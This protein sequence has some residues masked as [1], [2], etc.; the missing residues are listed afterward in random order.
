MIN[1]DYSAISSLY[2]LY[3]SGQTGSLFGGSSA[4]GKL[5]VASQDAAS[6]I[7]SILNSS[8]L[9]SIVGGYPSSS[10]G[11]IFDI[12]TQDDGSNPLFY[13]QG[14]KSGAK[15]LKNALNSI[16]AGG[17]AT[18]RTP[19]SS[20]GEKLA[21]S[22]EAG[23]LKG[24]KGASVKID[25]VAT[26][27]AN[28]GAALDSRGL[29]GGGSG[30]RQF[31]ITTAAGKSERYSVFVGA[32]DSN[33]SVLTK[34]ADAVNRG[35]GGF[36]ASVTA[37]GESGTSSLTI[38]SKGTG[39]LDGNRFSVSD[40]DGD[41]V[42][43]TGAGSVAQEAQDAI[44]SIDGGAKIASSSNSIDLG[45]GVRAT[46]LEASDESIEVSVGTD[47][48]AA[49]EAVNGLVDSVNALLSTIYEN[50]GSGSERLFDDIV[51]AVRTYAPALGRIGVSMGSDGYLAVDE[52][53]LGKAA[54][55]GELDSFFNRTSSSSYGFASRL[56]KIAGNIQTNPSHYTNLGADAVNN[57]GYFDYQSYSQYANIGLLLNYFV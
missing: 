17:I 40:L 29:F 23:G 2:S 53:Q 13:L 51:G 49:S 12:F 26:G 31:E 44:Y 16:A 38:Q 50:I 20:D 48:G 28:K 24:F 39:D 14:I 43:R 37:D 47:A 27:Q 18:K 15:N 7:R 45:G 1:A 34:M 21:V 55:N 46:L 56:S 42:S 9:G 32:G 22:V 33:Q 36:T 19:L 6:S 54:E 3:G 41:L 4:A 35:K 57:T 30:L 10:G 5:G 11:S 25:Q 52:D 8:G